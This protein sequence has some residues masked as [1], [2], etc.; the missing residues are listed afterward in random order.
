MKLKVI[1][2]ATLI[3]L[4]MMALGAVSASENMTQDTEE[5]LEIA[6]DSSFKIE[7]SVQEDL[8][9]GSEYTFTELN[10]KLNL[11]GSGTIILDGDYSYNNGSSTDGINISRE[12]TIDGDGHKIDGKSKSKIFN[13]M[14]DNVVLNGITFVNAK[15]GAISIN[16]NNVTIS[17]C[18]FI[19][20]SSTESGG[21]IYVHNPATILNCSF[22][23][24]TSEDTGG[25]IFSETHYLFIEDCYFELNYAQVGGAISLDGANTV[26]NCSFVNNSAMN[27]A[28]IFINSI[29]TEFRV[30][31]CSFA[32]SIAT[33]NGGAIH[34]S[35]AFGDILN[36]SFVNSSS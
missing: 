5:M 29:S 3:F 20:C 22:F 10:D 26:V 21:A 23:N 11:N 6:D 12:L 8:L 31:N 33:G 32:N 14:E 4:A 15:G 19:N 18:K 9:G 16:A 34:I 17:N 1:T 30:V 35:Q 24:C 36:C 2:I 27:G 13:I 28:A 7:Q 25:A